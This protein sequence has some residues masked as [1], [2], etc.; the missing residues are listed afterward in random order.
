[1]LV[2]RIDLARALGNPG[3][4]LFMVD[5]PGGYSAVR[6]GLLQGS[7]A[8]ADPLSELGAPAPPR[9]AVRGTIVVTSWTLS[10]CIQTTSDCQMQF[11]LI[12]L[13][14]LFNITSCNLMEN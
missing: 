2:R 5:D 11:T 9:P 6:P 1:M 14:T 4:R 3:Q 13:D 12:I 8:G 10:Q 7:T